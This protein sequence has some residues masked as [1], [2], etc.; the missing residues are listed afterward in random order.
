MTP[1]DDPRHIAFAD[2]LEAL[3]KEY[4]PIQPGNYTHNAQ[5]WRDRAIG[6]MRYTDYTDAASVGDHWEAGPWRAKN[7][8]QNTGAPDELI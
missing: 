1:S 4:P 2:G 6:R 5:F 7:N 3:L 8:A